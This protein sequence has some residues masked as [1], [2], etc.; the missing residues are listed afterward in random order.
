MNKF[1]IRRHGLRNGIHTQSTLKSSFVLS[2]QHI[3]WLRP[4]GHSSLPEIRTP[5]A[6]GTLIITL[7]AW[8]TGKHILFKN[9]LFFYCIHTI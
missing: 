7:Q 4:T 3:G 5:H 8:P 2:P 6:I 1:R 9:I